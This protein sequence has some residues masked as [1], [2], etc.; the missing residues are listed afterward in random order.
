MKKKNAY[1]SD[2]IQCVEESY[3][4]STGDENTFLLACKKKQK[5][6]LFI[7]IDELQNK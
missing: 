2:E 3:K 7:K 1:G 5:T 4:N 6:F